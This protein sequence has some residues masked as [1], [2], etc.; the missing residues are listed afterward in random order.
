ME[1]TRAGVTSGPRTAVIWAELRA[2]LER[3]AG[4]TLRVLDV[5]GGT[6]G[7][8]VPLAESGHRV[9]VIDASPDAL[10]SLGRRAADAGVAD[11]VR[12]VQGDGDQLA[13]L[14]EPGSA[15]LVLCHSVLEEVDDPA[16]VMTSIAAVLRPGGAA[17]IVVANRSG[18][19]LARAL[20]GHVSTA[21]DMLATPPGAPSGGGKNQRRYDTDSI[22]ALVVGAGL[23]VESV[24][25][26]R[27]IAD[28]VPGTLADSD[29]QALLRFELSAAGQPPFRDIATQLH[30]LARRT[31]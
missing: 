27:V 1:T 20:G 6:G 2:E 17:S 16:R 26:V 29:P 30:L 31:R 15:D 23:E 19:V 22:T 12:G 25:G 9:T 7:F 10:A 28:I 24:H 5:G 21:A 4:D 14:V 3:R 13:A 11:L 18:A 8:A